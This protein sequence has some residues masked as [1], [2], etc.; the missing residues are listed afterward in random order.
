MEEIKKQQIKENSFEAGWTSHLSELP[1][2]HW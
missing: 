1:R 2:F